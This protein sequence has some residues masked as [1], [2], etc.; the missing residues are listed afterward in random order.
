MEDIADTIIEVFKTYGNITIEEEITQLQH[1]EQCAKFA[2]DSGA[3]IEII[4]AALLHD[5]GQLPSSAFGLTIP[6]TPMENDLGIINHEYIGAEILQKLGF[7]KRIVKLVKYHV[8]AKRYL[9]TKNYFKKI[10]P[11]SLKTLEKQGG[12]MSNNE[13]IEFKKE[14]YFNDIVKLRTW[15]DKAKIKNYKVPN[16]D[17]YRDTIIQVLSKN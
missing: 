9:A 11:A 12:I 6:Q 16:I 7:T 1:A 14:K 17:T 4:V 13:I 5:I 2:R 15:D 8:D 10:S 3:T